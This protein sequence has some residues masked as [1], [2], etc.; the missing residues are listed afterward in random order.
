MC[1]TRGENESLQRIVRRRIKRTQRG[2]RLGQKRGK[3]HIVTDKKPGDVTR[4]TL[5][6]LQRQEVIRSIKLASHFVD[7]PTHGFNV[8][9]GNVQQFKE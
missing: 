3:V 1:K 4:H 8:V 5:K 2:R 7:R 6:R 9:F